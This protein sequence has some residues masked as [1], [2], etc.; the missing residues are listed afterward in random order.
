MGKV[1]GVP[2]HFGSFLQRNVGKFL[3][4]LQVANVGNCRAVMLG[5]S[6]TLVES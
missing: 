5:N 1:A 4:D 2:G 3:W 6:E